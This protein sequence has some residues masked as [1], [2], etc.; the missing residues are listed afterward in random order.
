MYTPTL[1]TVLDR[2]LALS[3]VVDDS[4]VERTFPTFADFPVR[5]Q[6]WLPLVDVYQTDKAFEIG[7]AH[8]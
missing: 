8:V 7:R 3:K 1:N 6:L 5:E 4:F 2:M